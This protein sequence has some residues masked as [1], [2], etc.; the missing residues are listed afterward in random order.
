M[1]RLLN[2]L[3]IGFEPDSPS[4]ALPI[5][6][7]P[8]IWVDQDVPAVPVIAEG[9]VVGYL[10]G[11]PVDIDNRRI[12]T[13]TFGVADGSAEAVIKLLGG[14]F[15]FVTE[16]Y[17][18][19]DATA[20]M[21]LVYKPDEKIAASS[22]VGL[23]GGKYNES[24]RHDLTLAFGADKDG[25]FTAGLTAHD[26]VS[27]LLPNHRLNLQTWQAE[28]FW[29][30]EMP[31]YVNDP[32]PVL[33]AI[34]QEIDGTIAAL[35]ANNACVQALT[36]GY[37]ARALLACNFSSREKVTFITNAVP[38]SELDQHL[39]KRLASLVGIRHQI[40]P[41]VRATDEEIETWRTGA[42]HAQ[43]GM[44]A[45]YF[46]TMRRFAGQF[47]IGGLGGEV[48]RGFL[49]PKGLRAD[50]K[51]TPEL[52][53]TQLKLPAHPLLLER[54]GIW[55]DGL[56]ERLDAFQTLDLAYV[57]LRM[58]PWGY[59]QARFHGEAVDFAPLTS[60]RQYERMY[61][62][63]PDFRRGAGFLI[64][65]IEMFA[66]ELLSIPINRYGDF[67][68]KILP[69]KRA[70]QRPDR[71]WRKAMQIVRR[72]MHGVKSAHISEPKL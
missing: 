26:G 58:G 35:T 37:D 49:W 30:V 70:I 71:A 57:E 4:R 8:A 23:L 7:G 34:G 12:V 64:R 33:L 25:W 42:G 51:I 29:P 50:D 68:D 6:G 55:L 47:F 3:A 9:V 19:P 16:Q 22:V 1:S 39:A 14:T 11:H 41:C 36:G 10:V 27:R 67:R 69:V 15:L 60:R 46:P 24:I 28:R 59:A 66:P 72:R 40:T 45:I 44:N 18:Y 2:A 32:D 52:L 31:A 5:D 63:P 38:G 56:P 20:S 65:I 21:G 62:L 13:T 61:S 53:L 43:S 48:G 17:V 54:V